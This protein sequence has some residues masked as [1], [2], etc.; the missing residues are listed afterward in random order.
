MD[1]GYDG[2]SERV[3]ALKEVDG[4]EVI[5]LVDNA[6]DFSSTV[7]K[8]EVQQVRKWVKERKGDDWTKEHFHLPMAEH[9]LSMLVRTFCGDKS[10]TILFDTGGS[11]DGMVINATRMGLNLSKIESIVLSH[12]H[13]DH[14]GG[15]LT[16][17]KAVNKENLPIIVHEEMFKT[18]GVAESDGAIRRYPKFPT[19]DEVKPATYI[20]TEQPFLTA[21]KT[22]LVTGRIPRKTE[23][24]NGYVQHRVFV[25][26]E[27]Q[28]D[29]WVWD[30]R[31]LVINVKQ[32]GLL[33]LSGCAHAGIINTALYSQRITGITTI[34][35]ILGGF[36]LSGKECEP[37]IIK[38]VK[39][40]KKLKPSLLIPS[41]C[42]GWKG[43]F[44]IAKA[45]P[46]AFVWN[47]VGNL[48]R[49]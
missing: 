36:H 4:A 13:Y 43:A 10:H 42:T 31:A 5:S 20:R 25:D 18:R 29:P 39:K 16:A 12:G 30:E 34:H 44:A 37:R 27:W 23:F 3:A 14:F 26:G 40:L 46:E 17:V 21:D 48:Y 24:E 38:T 41:H 33:L 15:L 7:G 49:F 11:Q 19:S 45:M 1:K 6:V 9:G 28:P 2:K 22:A 35:A 8:K 47:S 32:K